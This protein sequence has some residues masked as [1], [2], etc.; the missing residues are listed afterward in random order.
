MVKKSTASFNCNSNYKSI[1]KTLAVSE[2][3]QLWRSRRFYFLALSTSYNVFKKL[4]IFDTE[5]LEKTWNF[6]LKSTLFPIQNLEKIVEWNSMNLNEMEFQKLFQLYIL[7]SVVKHLSS[8]TAQQLYWLSF[9]LNR[10]VLDSHAAV[11]EI[12]GPDMK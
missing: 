10:Y 3:D 7:Y 12:T 4:F 11:S 5:H 1:I 8:S 2:G 6:F 9:S